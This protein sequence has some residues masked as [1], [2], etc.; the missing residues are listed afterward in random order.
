MVTVADY[1]IKVPTLVRDK[2]AKEAAVH[3]EVHLKPSGQ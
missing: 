1:G 2:I 3:V